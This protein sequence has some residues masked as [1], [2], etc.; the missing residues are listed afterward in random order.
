LNYKNLTNQKW[1]CLSIT[2]IVK[3]VS[4]RGLKNKT[5]SSVETMPKRARHH[6]RRHDRAGPSKD[7]T[8]SSSSSTSSTTSSSSGE[9]RRL[10]KVE[11]R[12]RAVENARSFG[13]HYGENDV[14]PIFDPQLTQSIDT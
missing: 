7:S 1:D 4:C 12:L 14:I 8:S 2:F 5:V 3:G 9:Q 13:A 11:K 6:G 10:R